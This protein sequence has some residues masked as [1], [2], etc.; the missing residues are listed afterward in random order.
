MKT[1]LV[2]VTTIPSSS[3]SLKCLPVHWLDHE[4]TDQGSKHHKQDIAE[5]YYGNGYEDERQN[6]QE[7]NCND[8]P[9]DRSEKFFH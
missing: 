5:K 3:I 2:P 7:G 4:R 6:V 1:E 9:V 8:G